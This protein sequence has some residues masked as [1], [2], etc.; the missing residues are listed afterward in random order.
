MQSGAC[1]AA[2]VPGPVTPADGPSWVGGYAGW[3]PVVWFSRPC[4]PPQDG[5]R[6][7]AVGQAVPLSLAPAVAEC[8]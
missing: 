6:R 2:L 3:G 1:S 7:G 8:S 4:P 5:A